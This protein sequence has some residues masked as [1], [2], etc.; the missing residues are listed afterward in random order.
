MTTQTGLLGIFRRRTG[1]RHSSLPATR[2]MPSVQTTTVIKAPKLSET[3]T[4]RMLETSGY[5]V[6][7]V[8]RL[9]RAR[10]V[11]VWR[12]LRFGVGAQQLS[13]V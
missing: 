1:K 4:R 7:C 3:E 12:T 10:Q 2:K 6:E 11:A 9:C 5:M 8:W 13:I